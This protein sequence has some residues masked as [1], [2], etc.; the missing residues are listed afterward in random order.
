M[1]D[2]LWSCM[3]IVK[4]HNIFKQYVSP[5]LMLILKIKLYL[6]WKKALKSSCYYLEK[7]WVA[8]E[9]ET[10][11]FIRQK[12]WLCLS[13]HLMSPSHPWQLSRASQFAFFLMVTYP[14]SQV[15]CHTQHKGSYICD[16]LTPV[17]GAWC[18]IVTLQRLSWW[19]IIFG[20]L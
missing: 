20:L 14:C 19:V 10:S 13:Y 8:P 5:H 3:W 18:I 9:R 2:S 17:R 1:G 12:H 15:P 6:S 11:L 7:P 4:S 16:M